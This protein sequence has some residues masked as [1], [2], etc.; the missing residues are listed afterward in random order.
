M[1][2]VE[3]IFLGILL[4]ACGFCLGHSGFWIRTEMTYDEAISYM[5]YARDTHRDNY[6]YYIQ[7]P[8]NTPSWQTRPT[9]DAEGVEIYQQVINLLKKRK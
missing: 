1:R 5:E 6:S 7:H 8:E 3:E 9:Q 2:I 4:V